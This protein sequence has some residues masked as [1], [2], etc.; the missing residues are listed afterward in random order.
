MTEAYIEGKVDVETKE[1]CKLL[2]EHNELLKHQNNILITISDV[3]R[4]RL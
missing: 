3:L 1:L 2:K 4:S